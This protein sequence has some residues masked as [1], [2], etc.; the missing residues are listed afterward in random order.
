MGL[1]GSRIDVK[2]GAGQGWM[3][4]GCSSGE[5]QRQ[6]VK[7]WLGSWA[8]KRQGKVEVKVVRLAGDLPGGVSEL[9]GLRGGP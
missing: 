1:R 6:A 4:G 5:Q 2:G 8:G 3:R 9:L 7:Q